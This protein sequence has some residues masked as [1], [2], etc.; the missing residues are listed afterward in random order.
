MESNHNPLRQYD[1]RKDEQDEYVRHGNSMNESHHQWQNERIES[2]ADKYFAMKLDLDKAQLLLDRS[3]EQGKMRNKMLIQVLENS[4][5]STL[6]SM[7]NYFLSNI[8]IP[9]ILLLKENAPNLF[10]SLSIF[11]YGIVIGIFFYVFIAG[12]ISGNFHAYVYL[13]YTYAYD[14]ELPYILFYT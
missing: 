8:P 6:N 5:N 3:F 2:F 13:H 1:Q 10:V 14:I 12:I 11:A 4:E 7:K 9:S